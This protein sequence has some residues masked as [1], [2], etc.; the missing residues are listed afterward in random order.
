MTRF[1]FVI[2]LTFASINN[3]L[4]SQF[5]TNET[6]NK[7]VAVSF[8]YHKVEAAAN[9]SIFNILVL[10]N[11]S[12]STFKGKINF[13]VPKDWQL[14]GA[15][16]T[17]IEIEAGDSIKLPLRVLVSKNVLGEIGYAIIANLFDNNG[18]QIKA[19]YCFVAIPR[20][21]NMKI[22]PP[23]RVVYF[24]NKT[25]IAHF[26]Y[27]I[28][29]KGNT[30]ENVQ[31]AI[32]ANENLSI[33]NFKLDKTFAYEYNIPAHS[34][35][36]VNVDVRL[37]NQ[38]K[39][40]KSYKT[41][42]RVYTQD[43]LYKNRVWL[44]R[45][46]N[47]YNHKIPEDNKC[48]IVEF[49]ASDLFSKY[50]PKYSIMAKG[51]ILFKNQLDFNYFI[52]K[53]DING[54]YDDFYDSRFYLQL[55]HPRFKLRGGTMESFFNQYNYGLGASLELYQIG[56]KLTAGGFYSYNSN[57]MQSF[58]G[59]RLSYK[60][61]KNIDLLL[62]Y[63]NDDFEKYKI[64][65][66]IL[67]S[68]FNVSF[69]RRNQLSFEGYFNKTTHA[70]KTRFEKHGIGFISRYSG[71]FKKLRATANVEYGSPQ[72]S[73]RSKGKFIISA[74]LN[75]SLSTHNYLN[76]T[77]IKNNLINS[78]YI[79]DVYQPERKVYYDSYKIYYTK[80]ISKNIS[81]QIGPMLKFEKINTP[82]IDTLPFF[83]F[84]TFSPRIY[85]AAK[86]SKYRQKIYVRPSGDIGIIY[87][88]DA[89]NKE[90]KVL[91]YTTYNISLNAIYKNFNLYLIFRNGPY[92]IYQQWYYYNSNSFTKWLFVMPSY[93]VSVLK[94]KIDL[95][96]RAAYRMDLEKHNNSLNATSQARI[97][98]TPSLTLRLLHA[99]N[100]YSKRN[101]INNT[102]QRYNSSYFEVALRKELNCRQ[103]RF[104]YHNLNVVF[105]KDL[106]GDREKQS[107]EPGLRNVLV[108]IEPDINVEA[109]NMNKDFAAIQFL[110]GNDGEIS[111]K[112]IV[113]GA[114]TMKYVLIG[115]TL[116]NFN[117]E[118][119]TYNFSV[120]KDETI[121]I[122]YLENNRIV[123]KIELQRSP[124]SSLGKI[125]ISGIRVIAED[126]KGHKYYALTKHDGSFVIYAP[127][128]DHYLVRVNNIFR[129]NFDI[130]KNEFIVK[131]NGYKQFNINF[132][133]KE[134]RRKINFNNAET[135]ENNKQSSNKGTAQIKTIRKTILSGKIEDAI[136]EK[137]L[138]AT[139]KIINNTNNNVVAEAKSNDVTGYYTITYVTHDNY[140]IEVSA[141]GYMTVSE[142]LYI[143]QI[144]EIQNLTLDIQ[145][146]KIKK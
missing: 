132:I 139:I 116:G 124:L 17:A 11:K 67:M 115:N 109:K 28:Y 111:Y 106:N 97:F 100:T 16:E 42:T 3:S 142:N 141:D 99:F 55:K 113:N 133:F 91:N 15:K 41:N 22:I 80:R 27:H 140:R 61:G 101:I 70:L 82:Y 118:E 4:L 24:E 95:D 50:D 90:N 105:F 131:F 54:E 35:T 33:D 87:V 104:Q 21:S 76:F 129:E 34:D 58:Y 10:Q 53:N 136:G 102:T 37:E 26:N 75:Y 117:R 36:V 107:G 114:Y 128:T 89:M 138:A 144:I 125:D 29:N 143:D 63:A 103:P 66:H 51:S 108:R 59:T 145:L 47:K 79:D 146:M 112:N 134:K 30:N 73:G 68:G 71:Y 40:V 18:E 98:I 110:T 5:L 96:F 74:N 78:R 135:A 39:D 56:K 94:N 32:Q 45:I 121:Y 13:T 57:N 49:T 126:T 6:D 81:T 19:E 86:Y 8:F 60:L 64:N 77:Y 2:L 69:L 62:G 23:N 1:F 31:I 93:N 25:Q 137:P 84:K 38:E 46:D 122:P 130:E 65:H 85:M 127:V 14:V 12:N 20:I 88:R 48:A 9:S 123:G 83:Y 119:Q 120:E 44:L 43:S 7:K 92:S 52:Y 72:Y